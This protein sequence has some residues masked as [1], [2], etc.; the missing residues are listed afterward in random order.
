MD[1]L[2][3]ALP[4]EVYFSAAGNSRKFLFSVLNYKKDTFPANLQRL[5]LVFPPQY[6]HIAKQT[7]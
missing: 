3:Q 1:K 5:F 7:A 6:P 2:S 4:G